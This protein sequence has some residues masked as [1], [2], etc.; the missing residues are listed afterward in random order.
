MSKG[1]KFITLSAAA[2]LVLA[3]SFFAP[4]ANMQSER[5]LA[6]EWLMISSPIDNQLF[7]RMGNSLG[8]PDRDMIFEQHGD[9]RTGTVL[10]EEGENVRPLGVWRVMGDKF[11][12]TFQLWC[13]TNNGPCGTVI[14]RGEFLRDDKVKGTMT[15]FFDQEDNFRPTG[16]DTWVFSFRGDRVPGGSN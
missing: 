13:P 7:S 8:F 10:R 12:A 14:M 2:F 1:T 5:T 15:V 11:S 3:A 4:T 16:Y 9:Q 6:G